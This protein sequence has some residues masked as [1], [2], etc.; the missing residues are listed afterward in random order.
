MMKYR[1]CRCNLFFF[2]G[3]SN[4]TIESDVI[5]QIF[6]PIITSHRIM[7]CQFGNSYTSIQCGDDLKLFF[8][9]VNISI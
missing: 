3:S 6:S 9:E 2:K 7:N 5:V 8:D 4:N 1:F